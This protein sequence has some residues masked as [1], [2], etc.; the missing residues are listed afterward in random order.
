MT[1]QATE[2]ITVEELD[3]EIGRR[4]FRQFLNF[5]KILDPPPEGRGIT[6][7]EVWPHLEEVTEFIG[8]NRLL[9]WLKA[10]QIGATWLL[11]AYALWTAMYQQGATV[12]IFSQGELEAQKFLEK[13]K[14][15]YDHLPAHLQVPLGTNNTRE[16]KFPVMT[17]GILA[18]PSTGKAGRS[19]TATLVIMDEADFHDELEDNYTAVKPTIDD[20]GGRLILVSTSNKD[21][22]TSVF[23]N[24]YRAVP[25]NGFV[26]VFYAWDVRP[27]RTEEWFEA[28][29]ATYDDQGLFE[30]EYPS[31]EREALA[32]AKVLM[33]FRSE[34][35][36]VMEK[37]L[38]TPME[39][40]G[41]ANIYRRWQIGDVYAAATDTSHGAGKDE[42]VTVVVNLTTGR[43]DADIQSS[44]ISPED[45]AWESTRLLEAYGS[46]LWGIEDNDWG[47]QTINKAR[48]LGYPKLFHR[49]QISNPGAEP[50]EFSQVGWHTDVKSQIP[51]WGEFIAAVNQGVFTVPGK[52]GLTQFYTLIR[53]PAKNGKIEAQ[54]GAHDDYPMAVAIAWQMR[55]YAGIKVSRVRHGR[56][57]KG[58]LQPSLW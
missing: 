3:L 15:I 39:V 43:V 55:N 42:A 28:T 47:M 26:K 16:M 44:V 50:K 31:N 12:L 14:F 25:L 53:N 5:V 10:R 22:M 21:T 19:A 1:I 34:A 45:L 32:P 23:K 8:H 46:P 58:A 57:R 51:L 37:R 9:V 49:D 6:P 38:Q 17:S 56:G 18:L 40:K 35:L 4:S 48:E 29:K 13:V 52:D 24:T 54:S 41:V 30:K 11:A 27:G 7:F 2:Q 20:I 33:A 36:E